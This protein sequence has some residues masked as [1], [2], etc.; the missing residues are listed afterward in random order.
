MRLNGPVE[1]TKAVYH[2]ETGLLLYALMAYQMTSNQHLLNACCV[3]QCVQNAGRTRWREVLSVSQKQGHLFLLHSSVQKDGQSLEFLL[4]QL[5]R[6]E[7]YLLC[8]QH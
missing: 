6:D 4:Y 7:N 8:K 1:D 3:L 2:R 5:Q